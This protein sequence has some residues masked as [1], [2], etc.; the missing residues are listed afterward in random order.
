MSD[1]SSYEVC[2]QHWQERKERHPRFK[3]G[4]NRDQRNNTTTGP[5]FVAQLRLLAGRTGDPRFNA[6][7]AALEE[8]GLVDRDN[9]WSR[10][11]RND[12][13]VIDETYLAACV[14]DDIGRGFSIR[15][16]CARAVSY[17]TLG[18]LNHL[19]SFDAAVKFV[20][21]AWRKRYAG[22]RSDISS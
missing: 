21:R 5:A 22:S 11:T 1:G 9:N 13:S 6:A 19:Q 20:E 18:E 2:A 10:V 7:L 17:E 4:L 3:P 12:R 15:L 14:N 8:L 16:A